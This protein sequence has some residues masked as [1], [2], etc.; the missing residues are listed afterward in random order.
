MQDP[1]YSEEG[2]IQIP[3]ISRNNRPSNQES[4]MLIKYFMSVDS[5]IKRK[6][7]LEMI[8]YCSKNIKI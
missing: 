7:I 4:L 1:E 6:Y 8:K 2:V 5:G 3:S